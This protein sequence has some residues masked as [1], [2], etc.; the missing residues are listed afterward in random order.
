MRPGAR[1]RRGG[2]E[3]ASMTEL[4]VKQA[5]ARAPLRHEKAPCLGRQGAVESSIPVGYGA[6]EMAWICSGVSALSVA[7]P[8]PP[9]LLLMAVWIADADLPFL[10]FPWQPEQYWV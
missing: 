10:L 2:H 1:G 3:P 9:V 4:V 6:V 7:L 5:R 8:I